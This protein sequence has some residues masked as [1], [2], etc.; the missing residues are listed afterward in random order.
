MQT[1]K[2]ENVKK[3]D[4]AGTVSIIVP[5]YNEEDG[6][7]LTL[8][9]LKEYLLGISCVNE[10]EI[11]VVDDGSC[12]KTADN[13]NLFDGVKVICQ[14]QNMGYGAAIKAGVRAAKYEWILTL[15]SDGQHSPEDLHF[16]FE[17]QREGYDLIIGSRQKESH[18][19]WIRRP[20][21]ELMRITANYLADK[22]IPDLN[23]GMRLFKKNVFLVFMPLY[24]N[25]FFNIDYNDLSVFGRWL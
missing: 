3:I 12:D 17:A 6:I 15:D 25:G 9:H 21:K 20:G 24:P 18:K 11:I 4:S 2:N 8:Q 1:V 23:S 13:A 10:Y 22:K 16:L 5:A 19:L 7:S 14:P